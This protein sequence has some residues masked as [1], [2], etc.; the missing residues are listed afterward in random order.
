MKK[1]ILKVEEQ[2]RVH[3]RKLHNVQGRYNLV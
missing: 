2:E 1:E 3:K